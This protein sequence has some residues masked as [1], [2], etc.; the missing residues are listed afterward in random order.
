MILPFIN[1][2]VDFVGLFDQSLLFLGSA[3]YLEYWLFV[4][5]YFVIHNYLKHLQ[6]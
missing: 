6:F 1:Q 2:T 4:L 3:N 5:M